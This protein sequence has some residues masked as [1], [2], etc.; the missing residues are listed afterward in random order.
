MSYHSHSI[1]V[2]FNWKRKIKRNYL[3]DKLMITNTVCWIERRGPTEWPARSPNLTFWDFFIGRF[4]IIESPHHCSRCSLVSFG[5]TP[6]LLLLWWYPVILYIQ[7]F[8]F[9][10]RSLVIDL[11]HIVKL[12][13]ENETNE[14]NERVEKRRHTEWTQPRLPSSRPINLEQRERTSIEWF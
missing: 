7:H 14:I 8:D 9:F 5:V 10:W 11:G 12:S 1:Q 4:F 6:I 3:N 2:Q 13:K